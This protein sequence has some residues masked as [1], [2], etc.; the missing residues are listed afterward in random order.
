MAESD[1]FDADY[2]ARFYE[3]PATLVVGPP[4]FKKLAAF[5]HAY[6][7]IVGHP[8]RRILDVGCGKGFF[9]RALSKHYPE[10]SYLGIDISAYVCARYGWKQAS[11][12][13]F[14]AT[15]SFDL[16][17]CNDMLQYL[18]APEATRAIANLDRLC[19]GMLYLSVLTR[20]D[21][22]NNCDQS[23][24]DGEVHLRSTRWYRERLRPF[25]VN[26]GGGVFSNRRADL[27]LNSLESLD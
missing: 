4:H 11:I 9:K 3:N 14:S 16:V 27:L 22:E 7:E 8:I 18:T 1:R 10:A 6:A 2:Y 19:N 26:C 15:E 5:I 13:T 23:R 17:I 20:E 12:T 24:T 21:W 25:F